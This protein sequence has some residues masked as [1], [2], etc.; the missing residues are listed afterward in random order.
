M[1]KEMIKLKIFKINKIMKM[2][3]NK[4]LITNN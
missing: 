1:E 2:R 3:I 4:M